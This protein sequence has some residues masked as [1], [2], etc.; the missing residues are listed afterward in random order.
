VTLMYLGAAG[1]V[2]SVGLSASTGCA[3]MRAGINKFDE[4]PY[5]D[6]RGLPVIGAAV[7]GLSLDLQFGPRLVEMLTMALRDCLSGTAGTPLQKV[8]LF[9]GLAERGRPGGGAWLT[10]TI[11][12]RVEANLGM[13]FH[14]DLSRVI[15]TGHTAGFE[16][17]RIA[18]EVLEKSAVP[19]CLVCAVD[20]YINAS[21]LY[22]LD[23]HWRLKREGHTDGVIPGEAAAAI[24]VQREVPTKMEARVEVVGLGFALE[25]AAVLTDEPL[26]AHGLAEA[27]QQALKEA[28]LGFHELDFRISDVTGENYGFREHALMEGRLARVVRKEHQ[29]LWHAADSIGDTG[30][31]AGVVQLA[32]AKAAWTKGYAPGARAACF[33]S[34]VPGDRAVALLRCVTA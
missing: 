29:P 3:A 25:K 15:S 31:A 13:K 17:L 1:M 6:A 27:G 7:P 20:S 14:P 2:C 16:C 34:A 10:D 19:G 33:T 9:V 22:W 23:Q 18:R 4:L 8:P 32:R 26:L 30:A 24:Y 5:W 11:I 21:S 28:G 12:R